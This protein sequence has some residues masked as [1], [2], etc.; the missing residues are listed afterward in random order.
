MAAVRPQVSK[1]AGSYLAT[2]PSMRL[3]IFRQ[4]R[5]RRFAKYIGHWAKQSPPAGMGRTRPYDCWGGGRQRRPVSAV[6]LRVAGA[7]YSLASL[8]QAQRTTV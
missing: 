1:I 6:G 8:S 2:A 5:E 7:F 3:F 4:S